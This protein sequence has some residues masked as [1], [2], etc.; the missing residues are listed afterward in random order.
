[1]GQGI[2]NTASMAILSSYKEK[3]D[4]YI[5][6]FELAAGLGVLVGP[7]SGAIFYTTIGFTGPFFCLGG[8]YALMIG[9]CMAILPN[10]DTIEDKLVKEGS[11]LIE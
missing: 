8:F 3:R 6:Y 11:S 4:L 7:V 2:N 5:S 10:L 1:M 9:V